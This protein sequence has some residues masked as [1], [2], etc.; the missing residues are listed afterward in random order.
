[1]EIAKVD[2]WEMGRFSIPVEKG[3]VIFTQK[4]WTSRETRHREPNDPCSIS[5]TVAE[6]HSSSGIFELQSCGVALKFIETQKHTHEPNPSRTTAS[7]NT[8]IFHL[9]A[10]RGNRRRN[11]RAT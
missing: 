7:R 3:I 8:R 4:A 10:G 6:A 1:M 11:S 5:A 9:H 2:S